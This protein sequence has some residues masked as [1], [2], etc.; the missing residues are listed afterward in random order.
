MDSPA[1]WIRSERTRLGLSTRDLAHLAG[2]AYP[3]ISRIENGHEQ[4]RWTTLEKIFDVLGHPLVPS[5]DDRPQPRLADLSEA[6][7]EDATGDQQPD[8]VRLRALVDQVRL[9][10][11]LVAQ[12]ILPEPPRSRSELMDTLLAAVAEKLA[13]DHGI[14]RPRWARQ[15][16]PLSP[17]WSA[18]TRPS[19]RAEA[20][21]TAPVQFLRRGLLI[22]ESAIWRDRTLERA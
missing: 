10:P 20:E 17:P 7:T 5:P 13:D 6:F 2:V 19:K 9:R 3:T 15:R 4:P 11:A 18:A 8:W 22:P 1:A 21:V 14:A 16:P 12:A